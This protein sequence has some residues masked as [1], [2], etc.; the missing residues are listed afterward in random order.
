[1]T[2]LL[3]L[4]MQIITRIIE[5]KLITSL[6]PNK[7]V[8]LVGARRIGKTSLIKKIVAELKDEQVLELN[9][10]DLATNEVLKQ[11]TVENYKRLLSGTTLLVIDEAQKIEDIGSILKLIVDEIQGIKILVTCSSMFDLSNKLG[12]PLTGRKI[13][14]YLFPLAQMEYQSSENIIQTRARLE[15][16]LIYGSY[17]EV[18]QYSDN[19]S[20]SN[21]LKQLV[22]DY[23]LKDI[24]AFEGVRNAAKML[25]LLRLIAFQVGKE[26]S[27][28][29]LGRQLGLSKNS[30]QKYLDLL[31]KVFVIYRLPGFSRNLRSEIV[32]SSKWY[33]YDNGIRNVLIANFAP[34]GMRNDIG[35]LW[36]NYCLYERLKYQQYVGMTVNNYFWRTYQ[37]QEIDWIEERDGRLF[38]FEIKW[39]QMKKIVAPSAWLNSYPDTSFEVITNENYL[40]WICP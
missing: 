34:L 25:D 37:Q 24:L 26:V 15:E 30:V 39:K 12:E 27:F 23:L 5:N 33:F 31:T 21:Y 29:E 19:T 22:N 40:D 6:I 16:R 4:Y 32:K 17:P 10:E 13:T 36:E 3:Y 14:F 18:M 28:D 38:A 9:G 35:E 2:E 20:K 8:V 11:R 7:V 1:L